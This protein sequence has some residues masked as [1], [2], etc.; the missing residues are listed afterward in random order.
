MIKWRWKYLRVNCL[1]S[2]F[3]N[4]TDSKTTAHIRISVCVEGH[5]A[6]GLILTRLNTYCHIWLYISP[7]TDHSITLHNNHS[8]YNLDSLQ[9]LENEEWES[10]SSKSFNEELKPP[11][12]P[13]N[14][15]EENLT[16]ITWKCC[17]L[18]VTHKQPW[19]I[20]HGTNYE[21]YIF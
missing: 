6:S 11:S 14:C 9:V 4:V 2:Y 3:K 13:V 20:S 19:T 10:K 7:S 1:I 12:L 15:W 16:H 18:N 21:E 8:V 5:N 17:A